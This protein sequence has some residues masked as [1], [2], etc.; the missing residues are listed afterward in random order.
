MLGPDLINE[1]EWRQHKDW[2]PFIR[3]LRARFQSYINENAQ[4]RERLRVL[5]NSSGERERLLKRYQRDVGR[6]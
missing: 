2:E 5:E 4:L 6:T 1:L 3:L